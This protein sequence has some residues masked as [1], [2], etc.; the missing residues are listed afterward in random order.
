MKIL[1]VSHSALLKS[2]QEKYEILANKFGHE[3]LLLTQKKRAEGG[4]RVVI[5]K[6][7]QA[8]GLYVKTLSCLL[9]SS[10]RRHTYLGL[11][12]YAR[13]F[14][15][16]LIYAENEPQAESTRQSLAAARKFKSKF[17]FF[18]W[19]NIPQKFTGRKQRIEQY[20]YKESDGAISGNR[21]GEGI[22]RQ[23]KYQKPTAVIPQYG[24]NPKI[25]K[26]QDDSQLRQS[27]R[28]EGNFIVGYVGRLLPE[29]NIAS[30][31]QAVRRLPDNVELIILGSG[32]ERETL[33]N[34]TSRLGLS[35]RIKFITAIPYQQ[36]PLYMNLFNVLVL[37]SITT[38]S[39]KEQFGRVLPEAMACKTPV[40]GSDSG[41]IPNVIGKAG[42][43]FPEGN[44]DGLVAAIQKLM[45]DKAFYNQLANKGH[46][47]AAE[48]YSNEGIA[49]Q[50]H[51]FFA[52]IV[53][54]NGDKNRH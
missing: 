21:D 20:V 6:E 17:V 48:L 12:A 16:Q 9:P 29:K 33:G 27:L 28:L 8:G 13:G 52:S 10:L 42:L 19:E 23:Q 35:E 4:G 41:E 34:L 2:Y 30:L 37:P 22:L 25:F 36:I 54:T 7:R 49:R 32:P 24:I 5:A 11:T 39:W 31:I 45:S 51:D 47:R 46:V 50:M 1:A 18:T 38:A 40:I 44:I 53:K 43:V 26:P 3:V 15:P 14:K